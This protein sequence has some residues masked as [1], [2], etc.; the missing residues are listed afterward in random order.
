MQLLLNC[1]TLRY[2]YNYTTLHYTTPYQ[3][4]V[5][6][7]TVHYTNYTTPQLQLQ[8]HYTN[9]TR[10]QLQLHYTT[11]QLQLQLQLHYTTLH[12][13]VAVRWRLQTMQPLQKTQLQPPVGPSVDSL[14]HPWFTT[15]NPSYRFPI[16]ETSATALCGTTGIRICIFSQKYQDL[17][18]SLSKPFCMDRP[19]MSASRISFYECSTF[20]QVSLQCSSRQRPFG[21]SRALG[22]PWNLHIFV[23]SFLSHLAHSSQIFNRQTVSP[24][25]NQKQSWRTPRHT[26][27][28]CTTKCLGQRVYWVWK[29]LQFSTVGGI[30]MCADRYIRHIPFRITRS[31]QE[32]HAS[33]GVWSPK[34][35]L[36]A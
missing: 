5:H 17:A 18:W 11:L 2:N 3:T 20:C 8:L 10:L 21:N 29:C 23:G 24:A 25:Q 22:F 7:T 13:A 19:N 28:A 9:C 33:H 34:T 1:T 14:C 6:N 32:Q 31:L 30:Y 27:I 36:V 4:T 15:T 12:P 16:F 26:I 35:C